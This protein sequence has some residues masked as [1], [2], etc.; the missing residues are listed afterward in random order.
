MSLIVSLRVPDG[1]VVAADS[2]SMS[3][4]IVEFVA[5]DQSVKKARI[6]LP[7][8]QIPFSAS[9]YTQ[10][11][12]PVFGKYAI[13]SYGGGVI[14][15]RSIYYHV[16]NFEA[17]TKDR[18]PNTL[19]GLK[20]KFIKYIEAE[21]AVQFPGY[22]NK[23]PDQ[24]FA[25]A[26]HFNSF[27]KKNKKQVGV[28]YQV[29]IKK[30]NEIKKFDGIGCTVGGEIKVAQQL[31]ELG[32]ETPQ[33][34]FKYALFSLQDAVDFCEY[35]IGT[36][37]TFQRFANDVANVGGEIDI[38]LITPFHGFQWIKQ[39]KLMKTLDSP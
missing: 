37:S 16:K 7:S 28:T 30:E 26:F 34:K 11:I 32:E 4:N 18:K 36:T 19:A 38:A 24:W 2:M 33:L 21:V 3:Q 20:D 14:N 15:E 10:K 12:F 17:I 5:Q 29:K 25:V 27:Q 1:L 23:A 22:K 31:W 13:S 9:S 39:K 8:L 6:K 35:L